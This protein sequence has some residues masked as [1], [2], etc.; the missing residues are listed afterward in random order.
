[1]C[2][3]DRLIT[4]VWIVNSVTAGSDGTLTL[5]CTDIGRILIDQMVFPPVIPGTVYPLEYYPPGRSAFDSPWGPKLKK[6]EIY[7]PESSGII[8]NISPAKR[9][10]VWI[11]GFNSSA[12]SDSTVNSIHPISH[13]V[14]GDWD[15]YAMSEAYET[16]TGG[17]PY[18]EFLPGS[19]PE[20]G[21]GI[22][23]MKVKT[24]GGGYTVYVSIAEDP[25]PDNPSSTSVWKGAENIPGGGIK[26]VKKVVIPLYLPDGMESVS[27]THL[28]VYKRQEPYVQ[29]M[30]S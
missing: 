20:F 15:T 28:D 18:F 8:D 7:I 4:G 5:S 3:R 9:G 22:N 29:V 16:M 13:A 2:I 12:D 27:Y 23:S 14:D 26:Y 17:K 10:E 24:W 25:D 11:R 21:S 6:A 19:D 1:M 30:Q